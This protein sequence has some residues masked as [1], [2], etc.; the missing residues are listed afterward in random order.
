VVAHKKQLLEN[1]TVSR[2]EPKD[3]PTICSTCYISLYFA[4]ILSSL[5][6]Q[7]TTDNECARNVID[8][9]FKFMGKRAKEVQNICQFSPLH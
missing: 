7:D 4:D 1:F 3:V 5:F 6:W 2:S 9:Y 8:H